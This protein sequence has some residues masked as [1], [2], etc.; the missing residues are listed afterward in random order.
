MPSRFLEA[1]VLLLLVPARTASTQDSKASIP[2][3]AAQKKSETLIREIFADQYASK[4]PMQRR[5]LAERLLEEAMRS[6]DDLTVCF[7]L[8]RESRDMAGGLA[9]ID[10]A[11]RAIDRMN[12][13]FLVK[14]ADLKFKVL[15][16]ARR[17]ARSPSDILVLATGHHQ[18]FWE[19]L[20]ANE[21]TLAARAG[22]DME[23]LARSAKNTELAR[24]A[25]GL[26]KAIPDLKRE[27]EKVEKAQLT[28]SIT[29]R[30]PAA[31][32]TLGR[33]WCF[34]KKDWERG[35]RCLALCGK[36]GLALAARK[37]L[38]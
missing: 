15:Q 33:F 18:V 24:E 36:P 32:L 34:V 2:A 14:S 7:V 27:F 30:D 4:D 31:N 13:L 38:E 21:F 17:S 22:K 11:F 12:E 29:P 9:D 25:A 1:L 8:L 6:Q 28:L 35:L 37:E 16:A 26:A 3:P 19:A 10:T 5:L 20:E 23:R